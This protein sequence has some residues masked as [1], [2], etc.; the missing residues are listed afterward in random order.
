MQAIRLIL[1]FGAT[2]LLF[3]TC[4]DPF[5][6][7]IAQGKQF[8]VINGQVTD[9]EGYQY[10]E[11]SLTSSYTDRDRKPLNDCQAKIIDD[12]GNE[13]DM[14]QYADG[15]YRTWIDKQY[16]QQGN[17][18]KIQVA[19]DNG[20]G[21]RYES[22]FDTLHS[23]PDIDS[24]Y[25]EYAEKTSDNQEGSTDGV[26]FY[27]DFNATGNF[28]RN[29]RWEAVETWEYHSEHLIE[30]IYYGIT[31][32]AGKYKLNLHFVDPEAEYELMHS[33]YTCY[34]TSKIKR[35]YTYTSGLKS[36]KKVNRLPLYFVTNAENRLHIKYSILIKQFALSDA[37]FEYW[38]HLESQSQAQ[39]GLYETQPYELKGNIK[40]I[41]DE[42]ETVIGY[43][44][45]S[46]VK[47][48]RFTSSSFHIARNS[49]YC[50]DIVK[51]WDKVQDYLWG[52]TAG[53]PPVSDD[54]LPPTPLYLEVFKN[55][56]NK[57]RTDTFAVT[58]QSC[59]DCRLK[60]GTL[61]KPDYW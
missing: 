5:T 2:F 35:I 12:K 25:Y 57:I 39:G 10:A 6:P 7:D 46:S 15:K 16:L 45:A 47:T 58:D 50:A 3:N 38:S 52:G 37:A 36:D 9:E 56:K 41:D 17:Q 54:Y 48:K 26:Q 19:L 53:V 22:E 55:G 32:I 8:V 4:I 23:C 34:R 20:N 18:F 51:G 28:A 33:L 43:F 40:C 59:Y 13:F 24:I 27:I 1:F 11:I 42:N 14:E 21:K 61:T 60:G 44:G 29:Y 30:G 49:E 31:S